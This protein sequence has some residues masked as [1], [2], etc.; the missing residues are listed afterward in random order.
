MS[1]LA[2][3]EKAHQFCGMVAGGRRVGISEFAPGKPWRSLLAE[4]GCVEVTD[5]A[6]TVGLLLTPDFAEDV[7]VY[8]ARLESELEHAYGRALLE[9]RADC[10]KPV[11]GAKLT[12]AALAEFD[13]L[14]G[15]R[16]SFLDS[17]E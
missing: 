7:S 17:D 11:G 1:L 5:R 12:K 3:E 9:M 15:E 10:S 16:R 14:K 13:A 6:G 2:Q 4:A 8:I